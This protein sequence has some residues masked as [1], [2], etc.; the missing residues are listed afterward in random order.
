MSAEDKFDAI[1]VGAGT[2]GCAC[3]YAL[4][5]AGKNVLLVERGNTAGSK[6]VTGGRIYT[7]ALEMLEEGLT[8]RAPLQRKVVREQIMML[9]KNSAV[10]I[11][12]TD[13]DFGADVPQSYSILRAPF[14]EWFAAE[15]EDQGAMVACGILVDELLE[16][17]GKIVGIKAGDDEMYADVVIAAD[18]VNS[19]IAQKAGLRSDIPAHSV[20]V[21]VKEIIEL[22]EK[23][24]Q[25]RFNLTGDEG[26]ARVALGCT[27][28]ISGGA[29]LY[30]NKSSISLGVVFNPEQA[31]AHGKRIHEILQDF[32][33]HPAI[34]PLIEGGETTEY[35]AH[36]VPELGLTG[37]PSKLYREGLVVI[38]DAA[39]FCIN[40]GII[41]R[42]MDMSILSGMAAAN[43][44]IAADEDVAKVGPLYKQELTKLLMPTMEVYG[45][46]H[47]VMSIPRLFT[48][49]PQLANDEMK[50]M[51]AVDGS[52]P[53]KMPKAMLGILRKHVTIRQ[54]IADGWKGVRSV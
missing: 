32:K 45:G 5:R 14:D 27:E 42:G 48:E 12:Y 17:D 29:F 1:I 3:A 10:T 52:I 54:L 4:A 11:D 51:F 18:G 19:F 46:Y 36:L 23:E 20:G 22:P 34:L 40:A 25:S 30:T 16:E 41:L 38:G 7:Y 47:E 44:I 39:G 33:M 28:G 37:I 53:K 15:A 6:N 43:A 49:Y 31:G 26:A 21:G 13:Y 50:F 8:A 35:G 9:N 2:A 24:I